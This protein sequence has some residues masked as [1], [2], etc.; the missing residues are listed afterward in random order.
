MFLKFLLTEC[1]L[2]T[3]PDIDL[4]DTLLTRLAK[5]LDDARWNIETYSTI[6]V[7]VCENVVLCLQPLLHFAVFIGKVN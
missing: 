4:W 7:Q 2:M 3:L 5:V 6:R 1:Q